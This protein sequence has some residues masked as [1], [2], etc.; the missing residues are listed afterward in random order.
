[1]TTAIGVPLPQPL[2]SDAK[3]VRDRS[4]VNGIKSRKRHRLETDSWNPITCETGTQTRNRLTAEGIE[5]LTG[6]ISLGFGAVTKVGVIEEKGYDLT[7]KYGQHLETQIVLV[8]VNTSDIEVIGDLA[9]FIRERTKALELY[10][11]EP[12]Q[13]FG[14]ICITP[15]VAPFYIERDLVCLVSSTLLNSISGTSDKLVDQLYEH[16][17]GQAKKDNRELDYGVLIKIE[18]AIEHAKCLRD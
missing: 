2:T 9:L 3:P 7:R 8:E 1:M 11:D 4:P 6:A 5:V 16:S 13:E 12:I 18:G 15:I 17:N 14:I 10:L